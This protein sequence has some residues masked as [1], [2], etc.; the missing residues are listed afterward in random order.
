MDIVC[1]ECMMDFFYNPVKLGIVLISLGM[2]IV[3]FFLLRKKGFGM[4]KKL[5]LMYSHIFFLVFPFVFYIFFKGCQTYFNECNKLKPIFVMIGLTAF[6][7]IVLGLIIAP[8]LFIKSYKK[9]TIKFSAN[10]LMNI[11]ENISRTAGIEKPKLFFVD[12]AKPVAFSISMIKPKIFVSV[13]LMEL[14]SKKEIV[15]VLLHEIAHIKNR[16]SVFKIASFFTRI[17]SPLARFTTFSEELSKEESRADD[18][19]FEIQ[20]TY[21]HI[22]SAKRKID[23]Y[24]A[25]TKYDFLQ[26]RQFCEK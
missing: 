4:N 22:N 8:I 3:T 20:K 7:A 24:N 12:M 5:G 13:G 1:T 23:R 16:T 15:A 21:R 19:A 10:W 26:E 6:I 11:M 17:V 25:S 9:R 2:V 18:F 14:L